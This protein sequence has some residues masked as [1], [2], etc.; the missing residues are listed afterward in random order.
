MELGIIAS[1][2]GSSNIH[3]STFEMLCFV[4]KENGH[5]SMLFLIEHSVLGILQF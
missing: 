5:V 1:L 3:H 4:E 2:S